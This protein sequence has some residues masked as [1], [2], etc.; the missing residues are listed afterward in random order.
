[1]DKMKMMSF[2]NSVHVAYFLVPM[3]NCTHL[4]FIPK[5]AE[6]WFGIILNSGGKK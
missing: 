6:L 3:I 5:E 4:S 1:M 2:L